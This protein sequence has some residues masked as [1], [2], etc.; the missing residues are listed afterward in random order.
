MVLCGI[1]LGLQ[2][3]SLLEK[4]QEEFYQYPIEPEVKTD[5]IL[6]APQFESLSPVAEAFLDILEKRVE[7][8]ASL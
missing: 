7:K 5:L 6:I 4:T 8:T 1:G 2:G 3:A